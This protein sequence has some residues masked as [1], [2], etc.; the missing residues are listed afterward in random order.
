MKAAAAA[1]SWT[2]GSQAGTCE[3]SASAIQRR[4]WCKAWGVSSEGFASC[5]GGQGPESCGRQLACSIA[6]HNLMKLL[7]YFTPERA[8]LLLFCLYCNKLFTS[9]PSFAKAQLK[10][11]SSWM[12]AG[13]AVVYESRVLLAQRRLYGCNRSI[14]CR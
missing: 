11:T 2:G 6:L 8:T 14:R 1:A 7:L 12:Q 10:G 3:K 4:R 9:I 5:S 13:P